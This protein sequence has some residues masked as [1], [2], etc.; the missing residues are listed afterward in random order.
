MLV[1][2][3]DIYR[4]TVNTE[5]GKDRLTEDSFQSTCFWQ[6]DLRADVSLQ[7]VLKGG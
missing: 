7:K 5:T 2:N 6:P 3:F 4:Y 1:Q